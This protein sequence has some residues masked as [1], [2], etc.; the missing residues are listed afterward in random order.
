MTITLQPLEHN[1]T[2]NIAI[3]FAYNV[4]VKAQ[5]KSYT[6]VKWSQTHGTFYVPDNATNRRGI[7]NLLRQKG[8]YIDYS[9]LKIPVAKIKT[10]SN[11]IIK[12]SQAE[13]YKNL[14]SEKRTLLKEFIGFLKSKR[15][16]ESTL[17]SYGHFILR[18]LDFTK[19][20]LK[21]EW[22]IRT[23]ELF[24]EKVIAFE[25]YSISS[26]RQCISALKYFTVFC[27]IEGF[28]SQNIERPKKSRYLPVVLSKEEI[29]DLLQVT[30]NLKHRTIIGLI[31]SSGLRIGELLNLEIKDIDLDRNQL[32]VKQGKGRKDRTVV[33]SQVLKPLLCNY[34]NTYMPKTYFVEGREGDQYSASS[35]RSFLTKSCKLANISK[36]VTPHTLRHSFATHMLENGVDLRYIQVLLG[37]SKPETTMIYTHVAQH[38]LME[39]R[40]PL[41]VT[42]ANMAKTDKNNNKQLLSR[43]F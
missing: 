25:N 3:K 27:N 10:K 9:A 24:L 20:S 37:H 23:I 33:L 14:S 7:Y 32:Y 11:K 17:S 39:I 13:L 28:D 40:S 36:N 26:H 18:F 8:Y 5:I 22:N 38:N 4:D 6:G 31:Y 35:I 42:V 30:K 15:L 1:K 43:K 2:Q 16:S 12:S 29:I 41:D 19:E 34:I 21:A